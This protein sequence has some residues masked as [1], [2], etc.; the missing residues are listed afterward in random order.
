MSRTMIATGSRIGRLTV[1]R[2]SPKPRGL[3]KQSSYWECAC[4][5][6][7]TKIIAA[8]GLSNGTKSCG[9]LN[10]RARN[11]NAKLT[12]AQVSEIRSLRQTGASTTVIGN[13]FGVTRQNI[14]FI[15]KG[16]TWK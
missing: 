5:C 12:E 10:K 13:R 2:R 15:C 3:V 9:C 11:P 6:G 4:E 14:N 7:A 16:V 8:S 1:L